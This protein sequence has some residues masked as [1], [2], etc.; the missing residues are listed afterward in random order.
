MTLKR[1]LA[2][3]LLCIGVLVAAA[4]ALRAQ[5]SEKEKQEKEAEQKKQLER[6]T[7]ALVDE[8]AG[9]A[10]SLKSSENRLYILTSAADLLWEHDQARARSLFW[11]VLNSLTATA[12]IP[13]PN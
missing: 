1:S 12:S 7:Y 3:S 8:I 10:L 6:K 11:D 5:L 2:I 13:R 4:P 9:G